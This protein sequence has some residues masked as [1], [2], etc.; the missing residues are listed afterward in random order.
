MIARTSP[1][2]LLAAST[3]P[4]TQLGVLALLLGDVLRLVTTPR[5]AP[6]P[7]RDYALWPGTRVAPGG[8]TSKSQPRTPTYT[9]LVEPNFYEFEA[10]FL[11]LNPE[12]PRT[13]SGQ[14]FNGLARENATPLK[15]CAKE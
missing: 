5:T 12:V 7:L 15:R 13:I 1:S 8:A 9:W 6:G 11:F 10:L 4:T 2:S 3:S 14:S